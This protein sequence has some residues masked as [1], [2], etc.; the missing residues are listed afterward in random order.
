[1]GV[2]PPLLIHEPLQF[3]VLVAKG[4]GLTYLRAVGGLIALLPSLP[5]D[6]M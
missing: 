3:L 1:V 4:H 6:R 5:R 2:V